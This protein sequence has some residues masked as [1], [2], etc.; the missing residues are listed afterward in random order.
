MEKLKGDKFQ[1]R[2]LW[3]LEKGCAPQNETAEPIVHEVFAYALSE[4]GL[5]G[6]KRLAVKEL[7]LIKNSQNRGF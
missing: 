7:F 5:G 4:Y 1:L 3:R 2:C 6:K